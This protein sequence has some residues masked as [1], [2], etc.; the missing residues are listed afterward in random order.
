MT[1]RV[2]SAPVSWGV[3]ERT[4][5]RHDLLSPEQLLQAVASLGYRAI[6][7]GPPGYFGDDGASVRK[8][9]EPF[10]LE[11][12]GAFVPLH[13]ADE[14]AFR[15]DLDELN[16]T[17]EILAEGA[18]GA[19]VLLAD[20]GTPERAD[21]AGQPEELRQTSLGG[22]ALERAADR[23][24]RAAERC[25]D[26]GLA[27][28]LH[29]ETGSYIAAP[30]EVEAL[31]ERTDREL[32]DL[33]FDTGHILVGGGDPV[34]L[35]RDWAER[36]SHVHLKDVSAELLARLR[37]GELNV[38]AA[39]AEGLFCPFGDGAVDLDGFLALPE[40]ARYTGWLVLEQDRVAVRVDDLPAVRATE[41][42][43]LSFVTRLLGVAT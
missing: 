26:R 6:E 33:C 41:E 40:L 37:A 31:L 32:L 38:E 20:A 19:I 34:R 1:T 24:S 42:R 18:R 15:A 39:W 22:A 5:G 10:G 7:L 17:I 11:V 25:R 30:A 29:P 36:I 43:N 2:A 21:V 23:L 4:V 3:W 13:L 28:A 35:A 16:R 8:T 12:V 27:A 14:A 9:T